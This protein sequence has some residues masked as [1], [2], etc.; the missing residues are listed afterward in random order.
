M[1]HKPWNAQRNKTRRSQPMLEGLEDRQLLSQDPVGQSM[2]AA[3]SAKGVFSRHNREFSYTTPS[4]G[5]AVVQVVG[6]GSLAGTTVSGSRALQL[7]Y[8]ATNA[9][10]KIVGTVHG[11][12]GRAPLVSIRNSQ[13]QG[14]GAQLNLTG[15]GS[16]VIQGFSLSDFDLVSGGNINLTAGVNTLVL[17]SIAPNTQIHLRALPPAPAPTATTSAASTPVGVTTPSGTTGAVIQTTTTTGGATTSTLEAG[18]STTITSNGVAAT[19]SSGGDLAQYLTSVTGV[20]TAGTNLVEP[21]PAGQPIQTRPPAPPGVL[22]KVNSIRANSAKPIDLLTDS[23]I[24]GYDPRNGELIRFNLNLKT[25]T[26]APDAG[27]APINV[28]GDPAVAG[29]NLGRDGNQLVVL[30]SSGTTVYAYNAATGAPVGSFTTTDPINSI[31]STDNITVLGSYATNQLEMINLTASLQSGQAQP[32]GSAQPF[33]PAAGFTLLGGLTGLPASNNVYATVAA[34]FNSFQPTMTQLGIQSIS[35]SKVRTVAGQGTKLTN[36]FTA[37]TSTGLT[38]SGAFTNV[39]PEPLDTTQPGPALG[40]ID[41][42]LA[43]VVG[44][45]G[46]TNTVGLYAAGSASS[47]GTITLDY[48]DLLVGLSANFRPD[49]TK[50]ALIDIQG[51]VQSVRGQSA[52]GLVLN[53][54]GNLNLVKFASITDSTIVGQP[55]GHVQFQHRARV[56]LLTPS[57]TAAGRNGVTV[58]HRLQPIGPLSHTNDGV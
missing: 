18:Q 47:D 54:N 7:V 49:L 53:D 24:F 42:N 36:Q 39:E 35:T 43:L 14:G 57:R 46:G 41:Q 23:K 37:G 16:T 28:P 11:G 9:F 55:L 13:I 27:F 31:G 12:N 34:T 50:S 3:A 58:N 51:N 48:P 17:D 21:L 30:V 15:L 4:G 40:S 29:V 1:T 38:Q 19:Y 10:S 22:L 56:T 44:A 20:F 2:A 45:S 25:G 8:G 52:T 5:H 6:R 32:L 26:G 33:T